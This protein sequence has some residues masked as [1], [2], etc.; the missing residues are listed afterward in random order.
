MN[1]EPKHKSKNYKAFKGDIQKSIIW[2][3]REG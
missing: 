2:T 1:H 3:G